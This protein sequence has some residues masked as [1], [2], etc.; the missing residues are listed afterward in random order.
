MSQ[1]P[2]DLEESTVALEILTD[3]ELAILAGPGGIA[4]SPYLETLAEGERE[5]V[6]RT[7]YRGLLARGIVDPPTPEATAAALGSGETTVELMVRQDVLTVVTLRR[8]ARSVVALART[9]AVAQDFWYA[10]VVDDVTLIEEVSG[11]GLHRFAL[12][13]TRDLPGRVVD[14]AVHPDTGDA[15]G[16]PVEMT[17]RPG[18]PTP[19][20]E[21]V[22]RLGESLLRTDLVVRTADDEHAPLLG[23]FTGP[24]GAWC[25]VVRAD[26]GGPVLVEPCTAE[27]V[28]RRVRAEVESVA[29][30]AAG[31]G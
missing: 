3:E 2:E 18:D 4:V 30:A 20:D 28:R 9:T 17:A 5:A 26:S 16:E 1:S 13:R 15:T 22:E 19:P 14:A 27:D 24:G 8:S 31:E 6:T 12:C 21:V 29:R 25:S 11:D 10:H 23:I 7:A